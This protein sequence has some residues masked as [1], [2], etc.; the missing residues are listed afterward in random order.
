[1]N[2]TVCNKHMMR[3]KHV[4]TETEI[5]DTYACINKRCDKFAG[6]DLNNPEYPQE[7]KTIKQVQIG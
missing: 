4:E 7:V 1:M 3:V 2:C 5:I 6:N